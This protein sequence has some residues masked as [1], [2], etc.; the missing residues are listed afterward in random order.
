MP[1]TFTWLDYSEH[2]RRKM[3]DV[4]ELF[5]EKTTRDELGLGS[6][7][8]TFADMLFPGTSTIQTR[9]KYFLFVPWIYAKLEAKHTPSAKIEQRLRN[10]ETSLMQAIEQSDDQSGLIGRRA[11]GNVLRLPSSV[12]W[13]GLF[14]W[15]I[16]RYP[17]SQSEYHKSLDLFYT[18]KKSRHAAR[19]EFAGEAEA[20]QDL[21][22]W[23]PH[24]PPPP[25]NFPEGAAFA[26][27]PHEAE[28]LREQVVTRCPDSLMAFLLR[29]Q[30]PIANADFAWDLT[31][32]LTPQLQER[33]FHGR[34][35]SE[36]LWGAQLLYNLM[37]AELGGLDELIDHYQALLD[38][39]W[40][41]MTLHREELNSWDRNKFWRIVNQQNPRISS[42]ARNF[43]NAW[44]DLVMEAPTKGEMV[45]GSHSQQLVE[46]RERQLKGGRARLHCQRARELWSGSAG[47]NQ[48]DLRWNSARRICRDI[49][50]GMEVTADA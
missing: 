48:L 38:E 19:S 44:I 29:E 5:G 17:G 24:L 21:D 3:L 34:N 41:L 7:R 12:Y 47:A 36:T 1:S 18:R 26:L 28:Y 25:E 43:V 31:I 16:R 4:I 13:Q 10:A 35:F 15:G 11:K 33:I 42:R 23:D 32:D 6:V 45:E 2:E 40:Q 14:V 49:L 27:E 9:A 50:A 30:L 46:H 22:N 39:W 8:D 37:L 20:N